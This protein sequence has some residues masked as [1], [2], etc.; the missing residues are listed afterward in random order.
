MS[1]ISLAYAQDSTVQNV[2]NPSMPEWVVVVFGSLFAFV[3]LIMIFRRFDVSSGHAIVLGLAV[4]VVCLP[5]VT[6]FEWTS[7]GFKITTRSQVSE[8]TRQVTVL[9]EQEAAI[10]SSI[11]RIGEELKAANDRIAAIEQGNGESGLPTLNGQLEGRE[12]F[13]PAV[14]DSIIIDS[15]SAIRLNEQRMNELNNLQLQLQLAQ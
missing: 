13:N 4:A 10:R 14:L 7:D 1:L 9:T 2:S 5:F 6:N 15:E 11:A 3:A 12:P 8:L